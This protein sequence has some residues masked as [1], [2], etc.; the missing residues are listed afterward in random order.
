[1]R[2]VR[3]AGPA[4]T[5]AVGVTFA[6]AVVAPRASAEPVRPSTPSCDGEWNVMWSPNPASGRDVLE[7]V[8]ADSRTNAWAVGDRSGSEPLIEHY[9]A[10]GW[11]AVSAPTVETR[12][13]LHGVSGESPTNVWAVG[14]SVL[15]SGV[16]QTL[17]DH[18][19]GTRWTHVASPEA[20]G[21]GPRLEAVSAGP[22]RP[23][24]AVGYAVNIRPMIWGTVILEHKDGKWIHVH[25][26]NPDYDNSLYGVRSVSPT[27]AWAVGDGDE[28]GGPSYP[29]IERWNGTSWSAL[30]I[31]GL[32]DMEGGLTAVT[33]PTASTVLA[34]GGLSIPGVGAGPAAAYYDGSTWSVSIAPTDTSQVW[35]ASGDG[36]GGWWA[37]GDDTPVDSTS[38]SIE[39]G[40]GDTFA[41]ATSRDPSANQGLKGVTQSSGVSW[42]VGARQAGTAA[43]T[44]VEYEC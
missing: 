10:T 43:H 41:R 20:V 34:V 23:A 19:D 31:P 38:T 21:G 2:R 5:L 40:T 28:D 7:S 22:N 13:D 27:L 1:V 36:K 11:H 33:T 26:P 29:L 37:V 9:T 8:W 17:I 35:S 6:L 3:P 42:A 15:K 24:W 44:L 4:L 18:Y 14:E 12:D 32:T 25:S 39:H 30:T 16:D